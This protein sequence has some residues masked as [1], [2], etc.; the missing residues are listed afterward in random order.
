MNV[1]RMT[2]NILNIFM[3]VLVGVLLGSVLKAGQG[4]FE[5]SRS[6]D[7]S[8]LQCLTSYLPPRYIVT[9]ISISNACSPSL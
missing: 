5:V 7:M 8:H 1:M 6:S 4:D 2:K 9:S 3:G